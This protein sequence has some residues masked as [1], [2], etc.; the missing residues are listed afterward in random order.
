MPSTK[1]GFDDVPGGA[2]GSE[3]LTRY[4]P[5]LSVDVGFDP[6]FVQKDGPTATPKPGMTGIHA[7]VDTGAGE[8]CIDSELAAQLNLPV[9]DRRMVSG[10]HGSQEVNMHL[11]QVRVP[12]LNIVIYGAFAG[13]HLAAGGQFHKAL[14]GRTFLDAFTMVYEGNTGTVTISSV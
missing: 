3:L 9:V 8:S 2:T 14:I 6:D 13:V 12:S 11:A 5:T 1:C 10:A 7:L 4:G